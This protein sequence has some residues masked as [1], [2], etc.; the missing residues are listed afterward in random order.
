MVLKENC[1]K[2]LNAKIN[3][4]EI[5]KNINVKKYSREIELCFYN[6]KIEKNINKQLFYFNEC[7]NVIGVDNDDMININKY[8][9]EII[10]TLFDGYYLFMND[11]N[12]F[13]KIRPYK[14]VFN[15]IKKKDKTINNFLDDIENGKKRFEK[16]VENKRFYTIIYEIIEKK[17]TEIITKE[18][19]KYDIFESVNF[20]LYGVLL[21]K[22]MELDD[23]DDEI[24]DNLLYDLLDDIKTEVVYENGL[25]KY[26]IVFILFLILYYVGTPFYH[27]FLNKFKE[28][29]KL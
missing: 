22:I 14:I 13:Y 25:K 1:I 7:C 20:D 12:M 24:I 9:T 8:N 11:Y 15:M 3:D 23:Y 16:V 18:R 2:S 5:I 29:L 4:K 27:S 17:Q 21:N 26:E 28:L 10:A 6:L 19:R